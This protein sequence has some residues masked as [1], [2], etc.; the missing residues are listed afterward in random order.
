MKTISKSP[1]GIVQCLAIAAI[2]LIAST[3]GAQSVKVNFA[4]PVVTTNNSTPAQGVWFIDRF[5]PGAFASPEIAPDGTRNTLEESIYASGHQSYPG[6]A[7][8]NTQGRDYELIANT[9]SM[10]IDLYVPSSWQTSNERLAGFW[11]VSNDSTGAVGDYPILEFQGPI[12]SAQSGPGYYPN[13]GVAG[14]YGW[15]N[16][17]STFDY[18]GLPS[19][20]KYNSWVKLTITLVPGVGFTYSVNDPIFRHGVSVN[21]PASDLTD[22]SLNEVILE[23]YNYNASYNIFWN[24]LTMSSSS[25]SC[26]TPPKFPFGPGFGFGNLFG[27][28]FGIP[29]P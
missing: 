11:G 10:S 1:A 21:S 3:A 26:S 6:S 25:L 16:V 28:L 17:T 24:N 15:N 2:A 20:F 8:F 27:N 7:F 12:T 23:G 4:T 5:P 19:G 9:Y 22:V 13:G 18:I 14:F 29:L